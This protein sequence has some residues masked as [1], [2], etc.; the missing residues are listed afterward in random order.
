MKSLLNKSLWGYIGFTIVVLLLSMPLF[1][2]LTKYYYAEDLMD[3]IEHVRSGMPLPKLDLEEDIMHGLIIQYILI[4]AVLSISLFMMM[5]LLTK[6]IWHPFDDTLK[7]MERFNLEKSE[8]PSFIPTDTKEFIRLNQAVTQLMQRDLQ[9]YK[10]RKEFTEN[11]SHELQTPIAIF[12]SKLDLLLQED[13]DEKKAKIVSELYAVSNRLSRLNKNMLLLA[14]IE[15]RL[16]DKME[17]VNLPEYLGKNLSL[18]S[19]LYTEHPIRL[20]TKTPKNEPMLIETN[21]ALLDSLITNLIVNAIRHSPGGSSI[22]VTL[23]Y[24]SLEVANQSDK[25]AL[26]EEELFNRFH[27]STCKQ[28]NGLGLAIVKAICDYHGWEI[29]YAFDNGVHSFRVNFGN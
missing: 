28:G 17:Q 18:F 21:P 10:N 3:V 14:K 27:S 12:Q 7:K 13:L 16:Y 4:F 25:G 20:I 24:H 11:A 19:D 26:N 15:N 5:V 1:Y 9:T 23:E 2:W 6:R 29:N 8:M 22:N